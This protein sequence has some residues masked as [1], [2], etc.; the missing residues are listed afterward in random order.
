MADAE[1][2]EPTQRSDEPT[3]RSDEEERN[4][5]A[6]A[7]LDEAQ[8]AALEHGRAVVAEARAVRRRMLE[9]AEQ[10]RQH[11]VAELER[12]RGV[13]D[14]T[15]AALQTPATDVPTV[16]PAGAPR[17]ETLEDAV[18]T[19]RLAAVFDQLRAEPP[20]PP[21]PKPRPKRSEESQKSQ[22]SQ[23]SQKPSAEPTDEAAAPDAPP[24]DGRSIDPALRRRDTVLEPLLPDVVRSAKRLLQDEQ[25][26]LLDAVRRARGKH[27]ATRLLPEAVRQRET[28]TALLAP[29]FNAAFL[30]GRAASGKSG[31]VSRA[32]DRVVIEL[33]AALVNPLRERITVTIDAVVAEGPYESPNELQRAL[34]TAIGARFREWRTVDLEGRILDVLVAAYARGA[35]EASGPAAMLRWLPDDPGR[36]PD[37]D[38]NALEPTL[39]GK[40]FP[41]G[42][43]HPPA[44]P[45]CRCIAL[46]AEAS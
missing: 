28:W 33:A 40:P 29:S 7:L 16:E 46:P 3:Q 22:T 45:G 23:E 36:C 35:Y 26:S 15:I 6:T 42:Q 9:D 30:G 14:E 12:L 4:A 21:K 44:H 2:P 18:P 31:R 10:R 37:C 38:D 17:A 1:N 27:E 5:R 25:N 11:V 19:E 13:I 43:T 20:P 41:T 39:K 34:G 24:S 8:Q 32:P